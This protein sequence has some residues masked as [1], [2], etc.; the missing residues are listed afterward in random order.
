MEINKKLEISPEELKED[1]EFLY[2]KGVFEPENKKELRYMIDEGWVDVNEMDTEFLSYL[3]D[4]CLDGFSGM[5]ELLQLSRSAINI[6][7]RKS[8]YSDNTLNKLA[9]NV[10]SIQYDLQLLFRRDVCGKLSKVLEDRL[11]CE[12]LDVQ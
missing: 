8:G 9:A 10:L 12:G 1:L 6:T 7:P 11:E 3:Y 4:I 5:R 2:E